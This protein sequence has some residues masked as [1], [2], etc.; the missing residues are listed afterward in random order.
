MSLVI[1][2]FFE[3][4]PSVKNSTRVGSVRPASVFSTSVM[5][6]ISSL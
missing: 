5:I 3:N 4:P 1:S 2:F 6:G